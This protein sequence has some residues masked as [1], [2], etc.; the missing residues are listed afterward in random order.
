MMANGLGDVSTI[1][2]LVKPHTNLYPTI[3]CVPLY[4]KTEMATWEPQGCLGSIFK[5]ISTKLK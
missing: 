3:L 5:V 2:E 4:R 1:S